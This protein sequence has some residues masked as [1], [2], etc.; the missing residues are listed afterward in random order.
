[1]KVDLNTPCITVYADKF[2]DFWESEA[3]ELPTDEVKTLREHLEYF[4]G[5]YQNDDDKLQDGE[6][7]IIKDILAK[8]EAETNHS[9]YFKVEAVDVYG[10]NQC[11]WEHHLIIPLSEVHKFNEYVPKESTEC[12]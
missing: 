7:Q 3:S 4:V 8:G 6:E 1:M 10:V 11:S 5:D 9:N 2:C 12:R